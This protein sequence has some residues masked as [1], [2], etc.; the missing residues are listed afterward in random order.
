M[1]ILE[2]MKKNEENPEYKLALQI[3]NNNYNVLDDSYLDENG[4]KVYVDFL[5]FCG[6]ISNIDDFTGEKYMSVLAEFHDRV[7]EYCDAERIKDSIE[8]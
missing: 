8:E 6:A 3:M 4:N 2:L 1:S 7:D 5:E